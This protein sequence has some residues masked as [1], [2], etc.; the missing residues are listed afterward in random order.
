[1]TTDRDQFQPLFRVIRGRGIEPPI[2]LCQPFPFL[3]GFRNN[4]FHTTNGDSNERVTSCDSLCPA[5]IRPLPPMD[6][7]KS[8][9]RIA[10]YVEQHK[11]EPKIVHGP[12][13]TYPPLY[14][15]QRVI[16][17]SERSTQSPNV[18]R[19]GYSA[20]A[21]WISRPD[22]LV[23]DARRGVDRSALLDRQPAQL[24]RVAMRC[25]GRPH[26]SLKVR[27]GSSHRDSAMAF[28]HLFAGP[29]RRSPCCHRRRRHPQY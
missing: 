13:V 21:I 8:P 27:V 22:T 28:G 19:F 11:A 18:P 5:S 29:T 10:S 14:S 26:R 3:F 2:R 17:A 20:G 1:M 9:L 23:T 6:L 24:V 7:K 25:S 4:I 15:N 12:E 16:T